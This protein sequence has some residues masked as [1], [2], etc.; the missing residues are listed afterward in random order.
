MLS[1][2]R[3]E[4]FGGQRVFPVRTQEVS[5]DMPHPILREE[6]LTIFICYAT[7]FDGIM[8]KTFTKVGKFY[9]NSCVKALNNPLF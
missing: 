2:K 8:F 6:D 4:L 1:R 7:D 5:V 9:K 3:L